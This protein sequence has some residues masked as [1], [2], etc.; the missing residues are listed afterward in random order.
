[1]EESETTIREHLARFCVFACLHPFS[2]E[3]KWMLIPQFHLHV[4]IGPLSLSVEW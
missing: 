2:W 3:L 1:M 4:T